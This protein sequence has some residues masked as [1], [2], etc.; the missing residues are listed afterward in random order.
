MRAM[1]T[2]KHGCRLKRLNYAAGLLKVFLISA[3]VGIPPVT[4]AQSNSVLALDK[5]CYS[6][7]GNPPRK[8]APTFDQLAK[9]Y[10][11][12]RGQEEAAVALAEKLHKEH[13]FGGVK[14]HEQ[15]TPENA[16]QLIRWI[17]DGAAK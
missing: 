9:D 8:N 11:K 15:L 3:A 4:V 12:Y 6:C 10:A 14:A 17:I 1:S 5:G 7:H 13:V 2:F 16:L